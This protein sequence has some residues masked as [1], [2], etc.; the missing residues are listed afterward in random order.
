MTT[1]GCPDEQS[2][3]Q[4]ARVERGIVTA[5]QAAGLAAVR[6]PLSGDGLRL[7][8]R[9]GHFAEVGDVANRKSTP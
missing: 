1:P 3:I 8:C 7:V 9:R 2:P 5:L 6:L 4:G